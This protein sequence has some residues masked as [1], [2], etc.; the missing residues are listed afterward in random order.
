MKKHWTI[1][2][3][4]NRIK[5]YFFEKRHKNLPWINPE[6]INIFEQLL[7]PSS[8]IGIEF[9]SGNSTVWYAKK[10]KKLI[11]I[12]DNKGWFNN[13]NEQLKRQGIN[14]VEYLFKSSSYIEDS[15]ES[16]Y[17]NFIEIQ[18]DDSLDFVV[19]DGN[20]RDIIALSA[21]KKIKRGGIIFLDDSQRYLSQKTFSPHSINGN[22]D[23]MTS[24]WKLFDK[25][26]NLW[27]KIITTNGVT[28]ATFFIKP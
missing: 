4:Y 16:E 12:E 7:L 23:K 13:V 19:V 15:K 27:R 24:N 14:N 18:L 22:K 20:F 21:I 11:S 28:D 17:F 2:Y 5:N 6:A 10:V 1:R 3:I 8:D 25:K 9:G 26:T